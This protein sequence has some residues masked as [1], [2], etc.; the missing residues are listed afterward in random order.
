M[1]SAHLLVG[2]DVIAHPLLVAGEPGGRVPVGGG[3]SPANRYAPTRAIPVPPPD[4]GDA[5]N[6][7]SPISPTRPMDQWS[8]K[9]W[10]TWS[11]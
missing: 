11:R 5:L 6:A 2:L 3:S 8:I 4:I 10:A 1:Q 7:A 9:T